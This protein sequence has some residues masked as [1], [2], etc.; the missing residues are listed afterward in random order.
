MRTDHAQASRLLVIGAGDIALRALPWLL[1]RFRVFALCRTAE[2]AARWRAAG[3]VPILGDLDQ[4][5]TLRR[6]RGLAHAVLLCAPPAADGNGDPRSLR[7]MAALNAGR[8]IPRRLVYISTT[9][10]YGDC[11]GARI[12]ETRP[13][14]A[15]TARALRRV[16]AENAW[17]GWLRR[18]T[19]QRPSRLVI[20]RTPG[21]YAA[22]RLPLAR[23][24]AGTPALRAAEDG[25]TS[26][27]HADDLAHAAHLALFRLAGGRALNIC[28]DSELRMGD[29]FDAVAD[30][31]GLPRPPRITRAQA[32]TTLPQSLLGFMRESRRLD[33]RRMKEELGLRLRHARVADGLQAATR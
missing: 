27:I 24:Q 2:S 14:R 1:S 4:P 13:R 10:V 29:W 5:A 8:I 16:A 22:D 20:L 23:L 18:Q 21:I 17:R 3:A 30:A 26:H 7:L 25:Y 12:D 15:A 9:G 11:G 6:L 32:E 28:D 31:F 19:G 33:N